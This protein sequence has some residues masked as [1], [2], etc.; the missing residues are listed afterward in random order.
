MPPKSRK[1]ADEDVVE[2]AEIA[3]LENK[4]EAGEETV[5]APTAA[6]NSRGVTFVL[7]SEED[8]EFD[9]D[10]DE[11]EE[12]DEDE[13]D[14]VASVSQLSQLLVTEDGEAIADILRG[15]LDA[16]EK[17]NKIMYRGLQVLETSL[18]KGSRR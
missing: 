11:D 17:H 1:P 13:D 14:L 8:E 10:G 4:P 16:L 6:K 15:I 2:V 12:D 9:D 3:D 7:D 18:A 5:A